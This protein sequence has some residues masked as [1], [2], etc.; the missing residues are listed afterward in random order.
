MARQRR[1]ESKMNCSSSRRGAATWLAEGI[2]IEEAQVTLQIDVRKLGRHPTELQ[3]LEIVHRRERLQGDIDCWEA[4]GLRF[5]GDGIGEGDV[6]PLE[7]ELLVL[8][9]DSD[10]DIADEFGLFEPEKIFISMS[11]NLGV[12]KCTDIG[13]AD[14]IQQE[15]TLRQGQANDAL[16]NI[17]V[18]LADKAVIFCTTVRAAKSQATSTRAWAQV[19]SVDRICCIQLS[20]LGADNTLLERYCPLA[21]EH[22]KRTEK[23]HLGMVLVYG[24]GKGLQQQ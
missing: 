17:Q 24:R 9:E 14:L 7:Q 12:E 4:M 1:R 5:L 16:H 6:Q 2:S 21:K 23:Q 19:H 10:E 18:H 13:A 3:L 22:L 8:E 15:L 20:K 11:S